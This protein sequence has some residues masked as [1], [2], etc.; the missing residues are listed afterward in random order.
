MP[1]P[2]IT[3]LGFLYFC[4]SVFSCKNIYFVI[5]YF[6]VKIFKYKFIYFVGVKYPKG[7]QKNIYQ[8]LVHVKIFICKYIY[9]V[10]VK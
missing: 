10:G 8:K 3:H 9:F 7:K 6:H 2:N 1:R 4:D 5:V